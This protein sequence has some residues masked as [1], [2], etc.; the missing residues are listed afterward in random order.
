[1]KNSEKK[2]FR[3]RKP[4]VLGAV[5]NFKGQVWILLVSGRMGIYIY[6]ITI[7]KGVPA[8]S[9]KLLTMGGKT[10]GE[11]RTLGDGERRVKLRRSRAVTSLS[12]REKLSTGKA[13]SKK[14]TK[15]ED[16]RKTL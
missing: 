7:K 11:P 1:V 9:E 10:V 15:R 2:L 3:Q 5:G 13:V 8:C 14:N 6:W 16:Q 12:N 4:E